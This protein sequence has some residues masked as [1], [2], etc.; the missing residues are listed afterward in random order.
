MLV[1]LLP[2]RPFP[3]S[4]SIRKLEFSGFSYCSRQKQRISAQRGEISGGCVLHVVGRVGHRFN[5]S[6]KIRQRKIGKRGERYAI[7]GQC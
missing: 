6:V 7:C 2:A 1:V 3:A 5:I 4:M